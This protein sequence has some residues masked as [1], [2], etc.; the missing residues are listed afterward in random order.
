M[1]GIHTRQ[2]AGMY[3]RTSEAVKFE[4]FSPG[5]AKFLR[6]RNSNY[7]DDLWFRLISLSNQTGE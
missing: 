3:D 6:D 5:C 7:T 2:P 1:T 4:L